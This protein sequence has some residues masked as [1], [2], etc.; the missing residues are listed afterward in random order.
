MFPLSGITALNWKEKWK[1]LSRVWLL[2]TP[3]TAAH[4]APPSVGFSRQEYWSEVPLPSPR[5]LASLYLSHISVSSWNRLSTEELMLSYCGVGEDSWESLGQ[6]GDQTS[7]S[8]RKSILNIHCK[9]WCW[10]WSSNTLATWCKESTPWKRPWFWERLRAGGE[11][12]DRMRWLD[13]ITDSRDMSL[14]KLQ[15]RKH[16]SKDSQKTYLTKGDSGGQRSLE[17]CSPWSHKE[18]DMT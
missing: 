14:S 9:D 17:C 8:K 2:T 6:K 5:G 15:E 16:Q 3:W 18:S 12:E 10:S 13:I 7:Q 11:E 1:L 4:Q